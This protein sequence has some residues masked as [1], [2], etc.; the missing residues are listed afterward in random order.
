MGCNKENSF[1]GTNTN[2]HTNCTIT[3]E[4]DGSLLSGNFSLAI[5]YP[6]RN[7]GTP[8]DY[9]TVQFPWNIH[10]TDFEKLL[11]D[12]VYF[13]TVKVQRT[14][15]IHDPKKRWSGAYTWTISFIQRNGQVPQ[16]NVINNLNVDL[17]TNKFS[18]QANIS[19]GTEKNRLPLPYEDPKKA[20]IGNEIDGSYSLAF[21]DNRNRDITIRNIPVRNTSSTGTALSATEFQ[22]HFLAQLATYGITPLNGENLINVT[23]SAIFCFI[24]YI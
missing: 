23:R 9:T 7:I 3:T 21:K 10:P 14:A 4:R 22:T 6:N 18:N 1:K 11:S 2:S 13:G 15:L 8:S 5:S 17:G 19:V 20:V 12:N 16:L 24:Y